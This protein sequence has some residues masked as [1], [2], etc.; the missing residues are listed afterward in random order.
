MIG[1]PPF[2]FEIDVDERDNYTWDWSDWLDDGDSIVSFTFTNTGGV[3]V[4]Q[5]GD[6]TGN[7]ITCFLS[8]T[9]NGKATCH[10]VSANGRHGDLSYWFIVTE[11]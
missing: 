8:A 3:E 9:S 7:L 11:K 6:D 10:V 4:E 1:A 5:P 2:V